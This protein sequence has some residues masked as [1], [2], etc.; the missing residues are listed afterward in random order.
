[1][2]LRVL[3]VLTA[4]GATLVGATGAQGATWLDVPT[5]AALPIARPSFPAAPAWSA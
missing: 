4:L 5:D 2:R 1:M 3:A